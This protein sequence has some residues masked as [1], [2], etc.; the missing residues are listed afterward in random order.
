MAAYLAIMK[1]SGSVVSM[2]WHQWLCQRSN[3]RISPGAFSSGSAS[4]I[5]WQLAIM[6]AGWP[7]LAA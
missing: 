6:A 7:T 4:G 3:Q 5:S 2:A 1:I